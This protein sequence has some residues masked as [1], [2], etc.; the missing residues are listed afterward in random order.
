MGF[1]QM[2]NQQLGKKSSSGSSSD[3]TF[4]S[5][6]FETVEGK[7]ALKAGGIT[8]NEIAS[9]AEIDGSKIKAGYFA[10]AT[11]MPILI[12]QSDYD[13]LTDEEKLNNNYYVFI[14]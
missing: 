13:N 9:N 1:G 4:N 6:Q 11:D 5:N 8:N 7:V 3:I 2:G 12:S 10:L 14:S